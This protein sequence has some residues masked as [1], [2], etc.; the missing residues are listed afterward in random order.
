MLKDTAPEL[1]ALIITGSG[2]LLVEKNRASF[3]YLSQPELIPDPLAIGDVLCKM[4]ALVSGS[5]IS[6]VA[7]GF[8][9]L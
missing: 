9:P 5:G 8:N 7:V 2:Q 4:L 1:R 6:V 3:P